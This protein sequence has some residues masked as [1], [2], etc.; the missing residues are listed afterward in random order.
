MSL[1]WLDFNALA[2]HENFRDSNKACNITPSH[3]ASQARHR[4]LR[5]IKAPQG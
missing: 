3:Q 5:Q 2:R 4:E 1:I